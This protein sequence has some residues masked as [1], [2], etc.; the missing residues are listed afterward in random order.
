MQIRFV[1]II[2]QTARRITLNK[3]LLQSIF[4]IITGEN[5]KAIKD[6]WT[7]YSIF[8]SQ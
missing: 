5:Q 4:S 8:K 2:R 1:T 6:I 3:V 7:F